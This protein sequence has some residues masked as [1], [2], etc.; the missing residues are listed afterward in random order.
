M[1]CKGGKISFKEFVVG[2]HILTMR[3]MNWTTTT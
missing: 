3:D 1:K 2:T